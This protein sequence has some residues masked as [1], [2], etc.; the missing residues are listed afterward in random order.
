M[1]TKCLDSHF[2]D[3]LVNTLPNDDETNSKII[4]ASSPDFTNFCNSI[5]G[6]TNQ[7]ITDL[8]LSK[9][10]RGDFGDDA[11]KAIATALANNASPVI[12]AHKECITPFILSPKRNYTANKDL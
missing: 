2:K 4:D 12:T 8:K 10:D 7:L 3:F 9:E 1:L 11:I 5:F 6:L